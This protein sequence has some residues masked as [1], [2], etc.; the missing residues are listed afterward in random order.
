M[1]NNRK[2]GN[3]AQFLDSGS[4]KSVITVS[5][6][7]FAT[8][9]LLEA[10]LT[11]TAPTGLSDSNLVKNLVDI[12]YITETTGYASVSDAIPVILQNTNNIIP[13][14]SGAY[15]LGDSAKPIAELILDSSANIFFGAH[16]LTSILKSGTSNIIA[17]VV[18]AGIA[19]GGD[20]G[21]FFEGKDTSNN[22]VNTTDY[23]D[24]TTP[25]N[26]SD[27]GDMI[28]TASLISGTASNGT[29]AVLHSGYIASGTGWNTNIR[30]VT[31]A[32][33][34]S[35][36]GFG[37]VWAS[38]YGG[39]GASDGTYGV[40]SGGL[41]NLNGGTNTDNI[42][43]ITIDTTGN[44]SNFGTLAQ[45]KRVSAGANDATYA[46]NAGG[47]T[48]T[49]TNDIQYFTIATPGNASDFGDMT[50]SKMESKGLSD[51]T[52]G[53]FAGG[54]TGSASNVI[55]YITVATP[56]NATDFGDLTVNRR[57]SAGNGSSNGTYGLFDGGSTNGSD[58]LNSIDYIT[59]DTPGNATDFG[60]MTISA[61]N[62][63][64]SSGSPS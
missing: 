27:F 48:T 51:E 56:A 49:Y 24:I 40:F 12:N 62:R 41:M 13:D 14:S 54:V 57:T 8:E 20:R 17:S 38:R 42:E 28:G 19:W 1:S 22:P 11:G 23:I 10:D 2:L 52:Y 53:V 26:A 58:F 9:P 44:A 46:V 15:D 29:R 55:E 6:G 18:E 37:Y 33:T 63:A 39:P 31:V 32:T 4:T 45:A 36:A 60:D 61:H 59:I 5:G 7:A 34:S 50:Q 47:Y 64:G 30:Y 25:G 21:I 3:L 35:A 16:S 43:Y